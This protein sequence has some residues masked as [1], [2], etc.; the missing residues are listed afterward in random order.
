M[1][2]HITVILI[3]AAVITG[4]TFL[5]VDYHRATEDEVIRRFHAQQTITVRQL[6]RDIE[7][8]LR[9]RSRGAQVLS[10]FTSVQ[11][12]DKKKMA[13]DI[14]EYF[15]YVKK[16]YVKAISVYD[17]K[18]TIIY[19]TTEDAI[20][21]NYA[22]CDFSRWAAKKENK[23]KLFISSLI[24]ARQMSG[25]RVAEDQTEQVPYLRFLIATPVYEEARDSR[26]PK[27]A[28]KF[29]GVLTY[30][31]DL[32][33]VIAAFLPLV[34]NNATKQHVWIVDTSGTVLFQSE[35]PELVL[36][37]IRRRD[38]TCM[39]CHVSLDYVE[40]VL[41]EKQGTIEYALREQPKQ[42][43]A[44]APITFENVTWIIA[45]NVPFDEASGFLA[46]HFRDTF[47]LISVIV[48]A[49]VGA[50]TLIYRSNRLKIRAQEET[51]Q[52]REKRELE[53]SIRKSEERYRQLVE[54]SPDAIAVHCEGKIVFVNP[55]AVRLLGATSHDE[56]LGK[57]VIEIVHPDEREMVKQRIAEML[58]GRES[59]PMLEEQ[60]L[61][62]DGSIVDV[63]VV[64][65]PTTYQGKPAVQVF[66]RDITE[67]KRA[68]EAVHLSQITYQGIF[69]GVTDAIYLQDEDGH[70]LYVNRAAELMYGYPRDY[71]IG[72]TPEFLSA[73]AKNNPTLILEAVR[74]AF[75]GEPQYFE[76]WGVHK[77]GTIFP[78]DV[79]LSPGTY[80]GKKVVIA[81]ARD[82]TERKRAEEQI[83]MLAHAVR[84][85]S[86]CVSITDMDDTVLFV[87]EGFL[88]TYG[89]DEHE[90][91]GNHIS[92]VRSPNNLPDVVREI[93]P[94]TLRGGW[95]G[96]L[97]NRRK[98]GSEFP[99]FLS[100]SVVRDDNGQ[101]LALIGVAV[102]ITE[103][104]QIDEALRESEERYRSLTESAIT[105]VYLIQEG[106][107]RYVNPVLATV[108][109][110]RVDEIVN[111]LGPLDLTA[112][113]DRHVVTE[114][115]R[116]R[117]EGEADRIRYSFKGLRKDGQRIEI[118][119]HGARIE[120]DS[121]P[122]IIGTLLDITE[123]KQ[124]E[125]ALR[126]SESL[127]RSVWENSKDGMRL[128]D[129][130]GRTLRVNQAFCDFVNKPREELEGN[131]LV[132]I[133]TE[134]E[135]ERILSS[136]LENYS[137]SELKPYLERKFKLW[138]GEEVWFAAT[139]ALLN[140]IGTHP[141]VLSIFRD[142]TDRKL[143]EETSKQAEEEIKERKEYL[144][145]LMSS[146]LDLIFTVGNDGTFDFANK[147]LEDILGY[148]FDDIKGKP[149]WNFIPKE[150]H[151]FMQEKWS[152]VQRGI[153]STYE[154]EVI[155]KDGSVARCLV[156]HSKLEGLDEYLA[157]LKDISERKLSEDVL[158]KHNERYKK[159][160]ENIF[161]FVPEGILVFTDKLKLF[162]RNKTFDDIVR[163]YSSKLGYTEQELAEIIIA[164]T[165]KGITGEMGVHPL[166]T[167]TTIR[168]PKKK[169][170]QREN[171]TDYSIK[172]P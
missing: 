18:G 164:E 93:L 6:A 16:D 129:A 107:F 166:G 125:E 115:I 9:D 13:A 112:P 8:Y 147:R 154:T 33:E 171:R 146:S 64:A 102:D 15:Q 44:F 133:Y 128:T 34:S 67:R 157:I 71:F 91:L 56:L 163:T 2:T 156:S 48:V 119:V 88:K 110:Y 127:F 76:F 42:L 144:E 100:T 158:R 90:L 121:K 138:N 59:V 3:T 160:I 135:R 101:P 98:D 27:P 120:Y 60:F 20:G 85:I 141:L 95:Q 23:G 1:K 17:E 109:G 52:W 130:N 40:K 70:F 162:N 36:K 151:P 35:H 96:E 72:K 118:E 10:T 99:I 66:V 143:A 68:E 51:K 21:R 117:V 73:P 167:N 137:S 26:Y 104:K 62:M 139:N 105:G 126:Q 94:A 49:L 152:E 108:F 14:Q 37:S 169:H 22:N 50:S 38:E 30:T 54:I 78:K 39:R 111:K 43:A 79:R 87:N 124:A 28:D 106:L 65:A 89:Y 136:Y 168:I 31:V 114:N 123:R 74:K 134:S 84:S 113:E 165:K 69:D 58:E 80:F 86:E 155:R 170:E 75:A 77:D 5:I 25:W 83:A 45:V 4:T 81:V 148:T 161:K 19:S 142:I 150:M 103:R 132:E 41:A 53:D 153:A 122:A 55:A 24:L 63:E 12:R 149:L 7:Q 11:H 159:V 116:K 57:H 32:E 46:K 29:V 131:S 92:I 47:L 145:T 82:I 61:R 140:S 172:N 97:L